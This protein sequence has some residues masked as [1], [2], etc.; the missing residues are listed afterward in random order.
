MVEFV[1]LAVYALWYSTFLLLLLACEK[2]ITLKGNSERRENMN[3]FNM[4]NIKFEFDS[5]GIDEQM[6]RIYEIQV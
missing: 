5:P 1:V 6:N 3:N 4:Y 2:K